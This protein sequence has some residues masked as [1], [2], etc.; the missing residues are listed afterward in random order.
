MELLSDLL[1][2]SE[3][4]VIDRQLAKPVLKALKP[5]GRGVKLIRAEQSSD[6]IEG[7]GSFEKKPNSGAIKRAEK[8]LEE[9]GLDLVFSTG[10]FP[11]M[12]VGSAEIEISR[13]ENTFTFFIEFFEK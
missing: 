3:K 10:D 2:L 9:F 13:K 11:G 1:I 7:E 6:S 5:L 8:A 4:N 12:T